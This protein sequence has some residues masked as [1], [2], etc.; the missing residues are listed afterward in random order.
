[1]KLAITKSLEEMRRVLRDS[2]AV[3]PD[4]VYW[5]FREIP[6]PTWKNMT[7]IPPGDF[8]GEYTKTV[9]HYHVNKSG[10]INYYIV[11]GIG[12]FVMQKKNM[13]ENNLFTPE[14]VSEVQVKRVKQGETIEMT[15]DYGHCL[16]NIGDEPLITYDDHAVDHVPEDYAAVEKLH[17]M[18][19]YLFKENG[20]DKVVPNPH[21]PNFSASVL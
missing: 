1:M 8:N 15:S 6:G 7:V 9:G 19:Y 12:V 21:N 17:G 13:D 20:K 2:N 4:P 10:G 5:V 3:G 14:I 16:V 18:A 11:S